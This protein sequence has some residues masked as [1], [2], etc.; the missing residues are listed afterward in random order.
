MTD[1]V[2]VGATDGHVTTI[3]LC[4]PPNNFFSFE[5]MVHTNLSERPG[6]P[7]SINIEGNHIVTSRGVEYLSGAAWKAMHD[8]GVLADMAFM[9]TVFTQG[10]VNEFVETDRRG[11]DPHRLQ[12]LLLEER[13]SL[14]VVQFLP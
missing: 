14:W 3:R 1:A 12:R 8:H 4:R 7:V 13:E 9:R 10:G 2:E 11:H 5:Y 6:F